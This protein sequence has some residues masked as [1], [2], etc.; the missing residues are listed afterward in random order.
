MPFSFLTGSWQDTVRNICGGKSANDVPNL[1]LEDDLMATESEDCIKRA[2][3]DWQTINVTKATEYRRAAIFHIASKVCLY[4]AKKLARSETI[5]DY[6]YDS[7]DIKWQDEANKHLNQYLK[8]LG[9]AD[10]SSVEELNIID[11]SSAVPEMYEE[12]E[13]EEL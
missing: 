6:R 3:P 13:S 9:L 4:L 2:S 8:Y 5:G 1:L 10:P 12:I 7:Q 11:I